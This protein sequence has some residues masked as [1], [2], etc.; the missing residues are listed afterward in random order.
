MPDI[1]GATMS[2]PFDFAWHTRLEARQRQGGACACCGELLDGVL[3][4]A[5]HVVPNQSGRAGEPRHLWLRSIDN[6]AVLC[7]LCHWRVHQ[8]GRYR[9]GAV[10]PPEYYPHSH[11]DDQ[12]AHRAWVAKL[13]FL[14]RQVW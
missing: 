10:A 7:D 6:C 9:T 14:S 12:I 3:E 4:H 8:D 1:Q 13:T 11:G 5:H 2:R